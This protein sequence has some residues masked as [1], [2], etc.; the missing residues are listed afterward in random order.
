[1]IS[2]VLRRAFQLALTASLAGQAVAQVAQQPTAPEQW[3]IHVGDDRCIAT[4]KYQ[5]AG[6]EWVVGLEPRPTTGETSLM[7][8]APTNM[9]DLRQAHLRTADAPVAS[10]LSLD[11]S[12]PSGHHLYSARLTSAEMARLSSAGSLQL[13]DQG[14]ITDFALTNAAQV[15]Q[16][17]DSCVRQLLTDWGLSADQQAEL[18]SFPAMTGEPADY[19]RPEDQAAVRL[20][21][22]MNAR[23]TVLV[24]VETSGEAHECT[25]I[26]STGD[27]YLDA[28]TCK[29]FVER[30]RY[31]PARDRSGRPVRA[32]L[33]ANMTWGKS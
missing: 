3:Q 17:L 12:D 14:R 27:A 7:L 21:P 33:V 32:P 2:S 6:Q 28:R 8:V 30:A 18:S 23:A 31:V 4:H 13:E 22:G 24:K 11:V 10:G 16:Y 1:M 26:H 15:Q 19:V 29:I 20:R 25:V 9:S 5:V